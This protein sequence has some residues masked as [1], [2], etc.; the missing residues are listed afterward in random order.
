VERHPAF[1]GDDG[2]R[3]GGRRRRS[4]PVRQG[5]G[6]HQARAQFIARNN[7]RAH[8]GEVLIAAGMIPMHV[9]IDQETNRLVRD[10]ANRRH[11]LLAQRSEFTI[12]H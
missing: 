12:D 10:L 4:G 6:T 2:Q 7:S 8:L 3:C 1:V 11:D 9:S 5:P